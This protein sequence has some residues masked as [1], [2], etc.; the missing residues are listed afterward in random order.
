MI[1]GGTK[2]DGI[3]PLYPSV[4]CNDKRRIRNVTFIALSEF[5]HEFYIYFRQHITMKCYLDKIESLILY[6]HLCTC[7]LYYHELNILLQ[8]FSVAV[9]LNRRKQNKTKTGFI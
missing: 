6:S 4:F 5:W 9:S 2:F 8:I 3:M 7:G 1:G